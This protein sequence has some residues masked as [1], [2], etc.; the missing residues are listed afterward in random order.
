MQS[1]C[2]FCGSSAGQSPM[3]KE[4]A[5]RLGEYLAAQGIELVYGGAQVGL[6][7]AV[8]DGCLSS[9]GRVYGVMPEKL[10][11]LELAHS[12]LTELQIVPDMH[13]RKAAMADRADAF[14]ALPGGVGTFEELFEVWTWT[15]L[16]IHRK[17]LGVMNVGGFYDSLIG[18]LD[19]VE[20]AGFMKPAH[21]A[22]LQAS[23]QPAQ[24]LAQLRQVA[25]P[26]TPKWVDR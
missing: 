7:G 17:P 6:M 5:T 19:Q 23:D 25:L 9:G 20:S 13:A 21:R 14:I 3:Y 4:A 15:Q 1:I 16:G 22:L 26:D 2:V 8:A 18:F 10:A 24:L 11:N 12:G